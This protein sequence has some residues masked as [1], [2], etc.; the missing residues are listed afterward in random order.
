MDPPGQG[1]QNQMALWGGP[2][3]VGLQGQDPFKS[4]ADIELLVFIVI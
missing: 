1:E 2:C 4:S 3:A